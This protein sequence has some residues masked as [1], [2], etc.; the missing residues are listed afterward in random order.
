MSTIWL[1]PQAALRHICGS[2]IPGCFKEVALRER[3]GKAMG[4]TIV[5]VAGMLCPPQAEASRNFHRSG[6]QPVKRWGGAVH[7]AC[8][9]SARP[10]MGGMGMPRANNRFVRAPFMGFDF[11]A[12]DSSADAAGAPSMGLNSQLIEDCWGPSFPPM[13]G[14]A[15]TNKSPEGDWRIGIAH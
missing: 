5:P 7:G 15:E 8:I 10:F 12:A 11:S 14:R 6:S 3:D 13:N 9:S 1:R 2:A 4:T